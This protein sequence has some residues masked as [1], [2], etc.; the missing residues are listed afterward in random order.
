[1]F[2]YPPWW[3]LKQLTSDL[4]FVPGSKGKKRVLMSALSWCQQQKSINT[5]C[6]S[7]GFRGFWNMTLG[8]LLNLLASAL[9][10]MKSKTFPCIIAC[11][12][13]CWQTQAW[14]RPAEYFPHCIHVPS[15][16][17]ISAFGASLVGL[18]FATWMYSFISL[19]F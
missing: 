8:K 9:S 7:K 13:R 16:L 6:S 15:Q 14:E 11:E 4:N 5:N 1:M 10:S 17:I 19:W 18:S 12:M 3:M 2:C